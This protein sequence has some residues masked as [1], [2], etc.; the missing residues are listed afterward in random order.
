MNFF[1]RTPFLF[2]SCTLYCLSLDFSVFLFLFEAFS[3]SL[4]SSINFQFVS[5]SLLFAIFWIV[6]MLAT[7]NKARFSQQKTL[8][9]LV[10]SPPWS[11]CW[12]LCIRLRYIM[13]NIKN[14]QMLTFMCPLTSAIII[15][16]KANGMSCFHTRNLRLEK[17][18]CP[19][20]FFQCVRTK[21]HSSCFTNV[22]NYTSNFR[23]FLQI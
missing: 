21:P 3:R 17:K 1:C 5:E 8:I 6:R 9:T 4:E 15:F 14:V 18:N 19:I 10:K 20:K 11:E 7:V 2:F 23:Q 16:S 12:L 13:K 22:E